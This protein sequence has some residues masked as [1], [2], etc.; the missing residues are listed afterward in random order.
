MSH[1]TKHVMWAAFSD[2]L[3]KISSMMPFYRGMGLANKVEN[4]GLKRKGQPTASEKNLGR[5]LKNA[6]NWVTGE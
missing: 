1:K 6:V 5:P 4:V 2:E 3:E